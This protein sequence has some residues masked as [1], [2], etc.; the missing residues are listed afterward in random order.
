MH[1]A[2]VWTPPKIQVGMF[3]TP[4]KLKEYND[5]HVEEGR[6]SVYGIARKLQKN[7]L[8]SYV[9]NS[10]GKIVCQNIAVKYRK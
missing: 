2:S 6:N 1:S 8:C 10:C 3:D 4:K 5:A 7:C 9:S